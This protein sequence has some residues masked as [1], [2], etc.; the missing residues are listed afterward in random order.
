MHLLSHSLTKGSSPN[1]LVFKNLFKKWCSISF[2]ISL[3]M[4]STFSFLYKPILFPFLYLP[5]LNLC[6]FSVE[7]LICCYKFY[8]HLINA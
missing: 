8:E 4:L 1:L 5:I 7:F 3:I 2:C 6:H